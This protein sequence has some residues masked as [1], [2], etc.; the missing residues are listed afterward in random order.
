MKT[1]IARTGLRIKVLDSALVSLGFLVFRVNDWWLLRIGGVK[2]DGNFSDLSLTYKLAQCEEGPCAGYIYGEPL[3]WFLRLIKPSE[4][5]VNLF[6]NLCTLLFLLFAYKYLSRM[7]SL[8]EKL[9]LLAVLF[10]PP[11]QLLL[12]RMN[13]DLILFFMTLIALKHLMH[14]IFS[15]S[16][17]AF[18]S[19][20]KAYMVLPMFLFIFFKLRSISRFKLYI[21]LFLSLG[22]GVYATIDYFSKSGPYETWNQS[23]GVLVIGTWLETITG[24]SRTQSVAISV[25]LIVSICLLQM[26][27]KLSET[28]TWESLSSGYLSLIKKYRDLLVLPMGAM[29]WIFFINFDYRMIFLT[30]PM[31]FISLKLKNNVMYLIVITVTWLSST[32]LFPGLKYAY[33]VSQLIGDLFGVILCFAAAKLSFELIRLSIRVPSLSGM[34]K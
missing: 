12:E 6:G 14:P 2:G 33:P 17:L 20:I 22:I 21:L 10:G 30:L 15:Y 16:L 4:S 11:T 32:N 18:G 34:G 29:I 5:A 9:L 27:T 19:L 24:L 23:F 13:L 3:A 25:A 31:A 8:R 1:Q 26:K 28:M 7:K